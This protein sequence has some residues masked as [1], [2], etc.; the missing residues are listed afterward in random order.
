MRLL[1][2][3]V[4]ALA[5]VS[6]EAARLLGVEQLRTAAFLAALTALLATAAM[7]SPR[8]PAREPTVPIVLAVLLAAIAVS[9]GLTGEVD[10]GDYRIAILMLV[11]FAA[12]V[13][14]SALGTIEVALF[15]WRCLAVYVAA[16]AVIGL[17]A[18]PE[19]FVRGSA[20]LVR[21]DFSGSLVA[22]A[23]L[24]Q[25][26]F[27]ATLGR[28]RERAGAPARV[29]LAG[30]ALLALLMALSTG[31]RTVL[32]TFGCYL[33]LDLAG[34]PERR[35]AL[36]RLGVSSLGAAAALALYT[37]LVSDDFFE[38]LLAG[39]SADWSSGRFDSQL[40]WLERALEQPLGLGFGAVRE[41]LRDGRPAIDG[42]RLLE[43]PHNEPVRFFVEA[44]MLGLGFLV[45][46]LG[47]LTGRAL[48]AARYEPSPLRRAVLLAIVADMLG[49]SLFQN[50]FN[51]IYYATALLLV[52]VVLVEQAGNRPADLVAAGAGEPVRPLLERGAAT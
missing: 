24:C 1:L 20:D 44:G 14:A 15:V 12:P 40:H 52:V 22:H 48:R 32:V 30:S 28:M 13:L 5:F 27:L 3:A 4:L 9:D 7:R 47:W 33:L 43:W 45:L 17:V 8:F 25:V 31:T 50:Y 41:L 42:T 51:S 38:R 36:G 18:M 21:I 39:S 19:V 37:L 2:G 23:G 16:T 10:P 34:D 29:L 46:M 6:S 35:R 49:Q 11:F 26:F